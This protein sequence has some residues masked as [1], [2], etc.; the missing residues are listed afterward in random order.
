V[1]NL[2]DTRNIYCCC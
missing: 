2:L 1:Y